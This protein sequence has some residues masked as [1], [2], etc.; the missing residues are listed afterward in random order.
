MTMD[1]REIGLIHGSGWGPG[2]GFCENDNDHSCSINYFRN[3]LVAERLLASQ[4]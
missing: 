3:S 2:A 1:V 4:E